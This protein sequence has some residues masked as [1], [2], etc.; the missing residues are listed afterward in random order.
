M[1]T[2]DLSQSILIKGGKTKS[3]SL[4]TESQPGTDSANTS[5]YTTDPGKIINIS[6]YISSWDAGT[7]LGGGATY[8]IAQL[9]NGYILA[10]AD[11][12]KVYTSTNNG[13][14]WDAGTNV[15]GAGIIITFLIQLS[16]GFIL[17]GAD[18]GKVYISTNNGT[19]WDAGTA[20]S[21][22][23]VI[24]C[25]IQLSNGYI[26]AGANDGKVYISTNNGTSW[27]AGTTVASGNWILNL[28]QLTNGYILAGA[29]GGKVYIST[30]NGTSWDAGTA[31]S[32]AITVYSTLQLSN[33]YILAG[34]GNTGKVHI[35]IDNGSSW[36]AGTALSGAIAIL[37]IFQL[38]G[39]HILAGA[40]NGKVYISTNNGTSWDAGNLIDIAETGN[41]H[42][43]YQ[44]DSRITFAGFEETGK[45]YM[46]N[47][48]DLQSALDDID[49]AATTTLQID[50]ANLTFYPTANL[51]LSANTIIQGY[52][53]TLSG[54][55]F[56]ALNTYTL[57]M[58]NCV[59]PFAITGSQT[60]YLEHCKAVVSTG[61][62]INT[63]GQ[64]TLKGCWF[65]SPD[66]HAI[67]VTNNN[68][69]I[70]DT[71]AI[72]AGTSKYSANITGTAASTADIDIDQNTFIGDFYMTN[73]GSTGKERMR[74][75]IIYGD[76]TTT[77]DFTMESGC[78]YGSYSGFTIAQNGAVSFIDPLFEDTTNYKLQRIIDGY[79]FDS[80]LVQASWYNN[81]SQGL[82]RDMGAWN[83]DDSALVDIYSL[84]HY[85]P[86]PI[87]GVN[88]S[89]KKGHNVFARKESGKTGV[90]DVYND[91]E[92]QEDVIQISYNQLEN[93]HWEFIKLLRSK[94][95]QEVLLSLDP[96]NFQSATVTVTANGGES[97]GSSKITITTTKSIPAGAIVDDGTY[98][99]RVLYP[100]PLAGVTTSVVVDRVLE[101]AIANSASL[102]VYHPA[103]CG[104]YVM[105]PQSSMW[106]DLQD[107]EKGSG[108]TLNFV[109]KTI[110]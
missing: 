36:D 20:L 23:P 46:S 19:S 75:N 18:N 60:V 84:A 80:P 89:V 65:Y 44:I 78:I 104:I 70:T 40:D 33:G 87:S 90:V 52:P 94:K 4:V 74:D 41:I 43:I 13:T 59:H 47:E 82:P 62:P 25:L 105:I 64:T 68:V 71:L 99:Y 45:I 51:T 1:T 72:T 55:G 29:T 24:Y 109:R 77:V 63:T 26:L 107:F 16:N 66:D 53:F 91:P 69:S 61:K 88:G 21:G 8:S 38:S 3:G 110:L 102:T 42:K 67:Q 57:K 108:L 81:T 2:P 95:N 6:D 50:V 85:M 48:Y 79:T 17:A 86:R 31:L 14:S 10:G 9:S 22:S 49:G 103:N 97:A 92:R 34:V 76:A 56:A 106:E 54:Y 39:G 12:G 37:S 27:D 83:F 100:I 28:L 73:T 101:A 5:D 58:Q 11:N 30:N 35:S 98:K 7:A 32:G 93:E 15:A 96:Q